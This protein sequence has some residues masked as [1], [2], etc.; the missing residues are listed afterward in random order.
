MLT[1]KE[2]A[3]QTMEDL[4]ARIHAAVTSA[5][6][7]TE[8]AA[9]LRDTVR[10][11]L[12]AKMGKGVLLRDRNTDEAVPADGFAVFEQWAVSDSDSVTWYPTD[13]QALA[14]LHE[15]GMRHHRQ[16]EIMDQGRAQVDLTADGCNMSRAYYVRVK[17]GQQL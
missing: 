12:A 13:G 4:K 1:M 5:A 6:S 2:I 11:A 14:H 10:M 7:A 16:V 9:E 3:E 8:V 17:K 15:L